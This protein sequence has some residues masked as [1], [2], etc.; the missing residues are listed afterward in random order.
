MEH[1]QLKS[2]P[3]HYFIGGEKNKPSLLFVH[4]AFADHRIFNKQIEYFSKSYRIITLD[5]IGHGLSQNIK[6]KTGI[7]CS[8]EQIK[9]ILDIEGINKVNLIGVSI[10]ALIAQD[11]ANKFPNNVLSLCSVGGYD[12]NNY[13]KTIEKQQGKQQILFILKAIISMKW[14]SRSNALQTV[15]TPEAQNDFYQM[16]ILFKRSS[17]RYMTKLGNIMNKYK[18]TN[19]N[20]PIL[21]LCGDGDVPL[22]I[23]LGKKWNDV[24]KKSKFYIIKNAGHCANMDNSEEFNK[25]LEEFIKSADEL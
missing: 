8:A 5:L 21:I 14:F 18:T 23:E 10:G 4:P 15:Q 24:E 2:M 22:S 12:I 13:D 11:F 20:Y 3:I 1:K 25:T 9:E 7:E 19:R 17:F 6:T 16:N